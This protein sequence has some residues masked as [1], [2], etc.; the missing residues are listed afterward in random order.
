MGQKGHLV[1]VYGT[2][3]KHQYYHDLLQG[4]ELVAEQCWTAGRLFDTGYG[5]PALVHDDRGQVYGEVY[6][7]S[8]EVLAKLDELEGYYGPGQANE[9]E[10]VIQTIHGDKGPWE[11]FVYI[12]LKLQKHMPEIAGGDWSVYSY[13]KE[14]KE[15][16]PLLYFA[17]GSCMDDRRIRKEGLLDRFQG[18][19]PGER[20]TRAVLKDYRLA[21]TTPRSDGGRADIVESPGDVVEGILYRIDEQAWTYLLKREGAWP[22]NSGQPRPFY[23]PTRV[24]VE[25]DGQKVPALTFTVVDKQEETAPPPHYLEEIIRGAQGILSQEYLTRFKTS[26]KEKFDLDIDHL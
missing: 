12:Y 23:R 5:Y 13:L 1:F 6:R 3:R 19:R 21:F 15:G 10:R 7:V 8:D 24:D 4:S 14:V 11:A 2:L 17:Y 20:K 16:K 9:Y 22:I 18:Y 25:V 26:L